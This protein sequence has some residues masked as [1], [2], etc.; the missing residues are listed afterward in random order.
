MGLSFSAIMYNCFKPVTFALL[1]Q[2]NQL[3]YN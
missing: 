1:A 3:S 2:K